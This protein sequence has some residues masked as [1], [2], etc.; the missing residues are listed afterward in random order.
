MR[1]SFQGG[2]PLLAN[3]LGEIGPVVVGSGSITGAALSCRGHD[4]GKHG[5]QDAA[6]F[7]DLPL[8][9]LIELATRFRVEG[10][11]RLVQQGIIVV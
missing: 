5:N 11:R 4:A 1:R 6:F 8:C 3:D 9:F 10:C 2:S 7:R